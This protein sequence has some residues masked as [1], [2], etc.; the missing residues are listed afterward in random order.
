VSYP[1]PREIDW[2]PKGAGAWLY[3]LVV[4]RT[5]PLFLTAGAL[6][7]VYLPLAVR[8]SAWSDDYP[9]ILN[10]FTDG[11]LSDMRP[12]EV[13]FSFAFLHFVNEISDLS[14]LR[15]VGVIGIAFFAV[16]V[17]HLLETWGIR[18][19]QAVPIAI[20][21]GLLPG[22][23]LA[24][25]WATTFFLAWL[26]MFGGLTG[27]WCLKGLSEGHRTPVAFGFIGMVTT[28]LFYPPAALFCWGLL[29][30][31]TAIK[32]IGARAMVRDL[33]RLVLLLGIAA[34]TAFAIAEVINQILDVQRSA[35]SALISTVPDAITKVTW[36]VKHPIGTAARPFLISSPTDAIA[37]ATAGPVL[38]I[39]VV[40]L[41]LRQKGSA[42]DRIAATALLLV[43]L[44]L[45]MGVH[46][47]A[48][49]NQIEYRYMIGITFT[50]WLYFLIALNQLR[51]AVIA[52]LDSRRGSS[53]DYVAPS[54]ISVMLLG[55]VILSA[56][57]SARTN[58]NQVFIEPFQSKEVYLKQA[59]EPFD[60]NVHPQIVVLNEHSLWPSRLNL[61]VFST[62]SDLAHPWVVEAN[63]RL[64]LKES[65]F[66][67]ATIP[68]DV[69]AP[70]LAAE[71]NGLTVDLQPYAKRL[72]SLVP[73]DELRP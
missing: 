28:L 58:I 67:A 3:Q 37:L 8:R 49:E 11:L 72:R 10:G 21:V 34:I 65:G 54:R 23:H 29:G 60:P 7:A 40:G 68:I 27:M 17:E 15:F 52:R 16:A 57:W 44:C 32:P 64:L 19:I 46:L 51:T 63:I 53:G 12:V 4:R 55:V 31:R 14:L 6:V 26:F 20:S 30:V 69:V 45:T 1:S 41:Y 42:L 5:L 56:A 18:S 50:M 48:I 36:F 13:L 39:T 59:L 24:A 47:V 25:G 61:G 35:R 71:R 66:E 9:M 2:L 38:I 73:A 33:G 62:V 70:E 43:Y 22:F